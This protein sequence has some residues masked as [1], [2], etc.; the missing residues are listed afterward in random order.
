MRE[1]QGE[2]GSQPI[3]MGSHDLCCGGKLSHGVTVK[4]YDRVHG[5]RKHDDKVDRCTK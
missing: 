5:G 4:G 2:F 3:T 1:L